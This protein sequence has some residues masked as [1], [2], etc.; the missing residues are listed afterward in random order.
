MST[1]SFRTSITALAFKT[2]RYSG[3]EPAQQ[4]TICRQLI[5]C[6][7]AA[8]GRAAYAAI[9]TRVIGHCHHLRTVPDHAHAARDRAFVPIPPI[10]S[11]HTAPASAAVVPYTVAAAPAG[12]LPR[13]SHKGLALVLKCPAPAS[14]SPPTRS[15]QPPPPAPAPS[16]APLASSCALRLPTLQHMTYTTCQSSARPMVSDSSPALT[17]TV[18]APLLPLLWRHQ[19]CSWG[20]T[21]GTVLPLLL[22]HLL[23]HAPLSHPPPLTLLPASHPPPAPLASSCPLRLPTSCRSTCASISHSSSCLDTCVV[24]GDHQTHAHT[25]LKYTRRLVFQL[26]N[27]C[28]WACT[29]SCTGGVHRAKVHGQCI[30]VQ[31]LDTCTPSAWSRAVRVTLE[32]IRRQ[33]A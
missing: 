17:T 16:P 25:R 14:P 1:A 22:F 13:P 28:A 24:G 29:M 31:L 30:L 5:P 8:A 33:A 15:A 11:D 27:T 23:P 18:Q 10:C 20:Q 7:H 32:C 26:L 9:S 12:A 21:M 2:S 4:K 19:C 3:R 6:V